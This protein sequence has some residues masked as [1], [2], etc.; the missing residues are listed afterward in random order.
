MKNK[1]GFISMSLVYSFLVLF[2]FLMMSIINCYLKKNTY[3]EALDKQVSKDISI[4]K[5]AKQ[6][7]LSTMLQDNIAIPS[8]TLDLRQISNNDIK[9]GNGLFYVEDKNVTDE[10]NDGYGAKIYF[11]RGAIDNNYVVFGKEVKRN[12]QGQVNDQKRICWRI[13]RTNEDGSIRLIYSGLYDEVSNSCPS[14]GQYLNL[15]NFSE[16]YKTYAKGADYSIVPYVIA[17][18]NPATEN[19]YIDAAYVGYTYGV[20]ISSQEN[21]EEFMTGETDQSLYNYTHYANTSSKN[22]GE[23]PILYESNVKKVL[24]NYILNHTNLAFSTELDI[25]NKYELEGSTEG[26]VLMMPFESDRVA[27]GIFCND[28][29]FTK[30]SEIKN[31]EGLNKRPSDPPV[32]DETEID[33][34]TSKGY[35]NYPTFYNAYVRYLTGKPS[36]KCKETNDRYSLRIISGGTNT[37]PNA[38]AYAIGLPTMDDIIYAGGSMQNN[39]GYFMKSDT[40]YWTMTP[41]TSGLGETVDVAPE[42]GPYVIAVDANGALIESPV[43]TS[44]HNL[45]PVISI[46]QET[47]V[48]SGTGLIN[49]PY[50][51]K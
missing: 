34:K 1:N 29:T 9:N 36:Y 42:D 50:I 49:E 15:S 14:T 7:L 40:S 2:L 17:P 43:D 3:L 13:M 32:M 4:T 31:L 45:R 22:R 37:N 19:D 18:D 39:T 10:N 11:Y 33:E 48:M 24:D 16:E 26:N 30:Y 35:Y 21:P 28:R 6:S 20:S 46:K 12:T 23:T 5:E 38:L 47:L 51:L 25:A 41:M 44:A 8:H 27:N